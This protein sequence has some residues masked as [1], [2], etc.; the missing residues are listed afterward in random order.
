MSGVPAAFC[1]VV[2]CRRLG[3]KLVDSG[4]LCTK[5]YEEILSVACSGANQEIPSQEKLGSKG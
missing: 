1:S 2:D 3:S 5:H 4:F